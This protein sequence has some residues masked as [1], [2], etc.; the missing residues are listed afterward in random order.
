M[1]DFEHLP[2][3]G[4]VDDCQIVEINNKFGYAWDGQP[5]LKIGDSVVLPSKYDLGEWVGT[6]TELGSRWP[7]EFTKVVRIATIEDVEAYE[8]RL[9]EAVKRRAER[10]K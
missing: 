2:I 3:R 1:T 7:H 4:M 9:E 6:V 5:F 8:V 10:K